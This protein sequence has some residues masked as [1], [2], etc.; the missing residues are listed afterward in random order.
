MNY[1][2]V[3]HFFFA[4]IFI[5]SRA[6]NESW[7]LGNSVFN[8][9]QFVI[10]KIWPS[11][12]PNQENAPK[13]MCKCYSRP[14]VHFHCKTNVPEVSMAEAM[15]RAAR[16]YTF[17][18]LTQFS[19]VLC[20]QTISEYPITYDFSGISIQRFLYRL[21]SCA[22][23]SCFLYIYLNIYQSGATFRSWL[24]TE[25]SGTILFLRNSVYLI[26]LSKGQHSS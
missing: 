20:S 5:Y 25:S 24:F 21:G 16:K 2:R 19:I 6:Q 4:E 11:T 17:K 3:V 14:S 9:T 8:F 22:Y 7:V 1:F 13:F 18:K 10:M 15:R 26:D 12:I 23:Y